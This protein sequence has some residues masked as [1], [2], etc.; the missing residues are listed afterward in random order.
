MPSIKIKDE[1]CLVD[2]AMQESGAVDAVVSLAMLNDV[3]ITKDFSAGESVVLGGVLNTRVSAV[4]KD[5][6]LFPAS[7]TVSDE[8][9]PGG[10][11][12]MI[13]AL[14]FIVS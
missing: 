11:G 14:D 5:N 9:E 1:Q 8:I 2:I 7:N 4:F 6:G 12:Y 10:I 3:E 13:I